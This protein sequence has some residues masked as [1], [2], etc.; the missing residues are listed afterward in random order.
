MKKNG[1]IT[2]T[3]VFLLLFG[4]LLSLSGLREA[5][6]GKMDGYLLKIKAKKT[7][8]YDLYNPSKSMDYTDRKSTR[9]N[10]RHWHLS[11]MP[12]SG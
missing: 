2:K 8:W 9:V 5:K 1:R 10:S 7:G 6:A 3:I 12:S 11:R 4:M